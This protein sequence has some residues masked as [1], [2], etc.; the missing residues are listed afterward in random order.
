MQVDLT[1]AHSVSSVLT[2]GSSASE[3]WV[4]SYSIDYSTEN[5][6]PPESTILDTESGAPEVFAGNVDRTS[7][8]ENVFG[9]VVIARY[10]RLNIITN[11]NYPAMRWGL[12]GCPVGEY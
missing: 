7:I 8:V 9:N 2:Q 11:E 3:S 12:K 5:S 1:N 10:V 6:D 4:T